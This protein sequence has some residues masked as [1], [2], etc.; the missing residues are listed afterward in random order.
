[1]MSNDWHVL[2]NGRAAFRQIHD[3][4]NQGISDLAISFKEFGSYLRNDDVQIGLQEVLDVLVDERNIDDQLAITEVVLNDIMQLI[5][6]E[7]DVM[8]EIL[9]VFRCN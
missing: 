3:E 1:M 5:N 6:N 7:L 9:R 4:I 2:Q 8:P